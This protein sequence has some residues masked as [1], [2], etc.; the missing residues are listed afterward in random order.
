MATFATLLDEYAVPQWREHYLDYE[1][2]KE[3]LGQIYE[4]A[5]HRPPS[6]IDFEDDV[7]DDDGAVGDTD[8]PYVDDLDDDDFDEEEEL[9]E[10]TPESTSAEAETDEPVDRRE[11][12]RRRRKQRREEQ[13]R[14]AKRREKRRSQR[15]NMAAKL[16][17]DRAARMGPAHTAFFAAVDEEIERL[18][19]FVGAAEAFF[20]RR[21]ARLVERVAEVHQSLQPEQLGEMDASERERLRCDMQ[22]LQY[23][24]LVTGRGLQGLEDYSLI[25]LRGFEKALQQYERLSGAAAG[26][27]SGDGVRGVLAAI[28]K[29]PFYAAC[30]FERACSQLETLFYKHATLMKRV[31]KGTHKVPQTTQLRTARERLMTPR[32]A[33]E[34]PELAEFVCVFGGA[35]A[36]RMESDAIDAINHMVSPSVNAP[37]SL[38]DAKKSQEFWRQCRRLDAASLVTLAGVS[39]RVRGRHHSRSRSTSPSSPKELSDTLSTSGSGSESKRKKSRLSPLLLA[40]AA[41]VQPSKQDDLANGRIRGATEDGLDDVDDEEES[42]PL[43]AF[44]GGMGARLHDAALEEGPQARARKREERRRHKEEH[45]NLQQHLQQ[46]QRDVIQQQEQYEKM[47]KAKQKAKRRLPFPLVLLGVLMSLIA[48]ALAYYSNRHR[49]Q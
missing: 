12:R 6:A 44:G 4:S 32:E 9:E 49:F 41:V 2:L 39:R 22:A 24:M 10:P 26:C 35:E 25:N 47:L 20:R 5:H 21:V 18:N 15:L 16:T 29:E 28:E 34:R 19:R 3:R 30:P 13:Q 40:A 48:I 11:E 17:R 27:D 43:I 38:R 45:M 1:A 37:V 36:E 46:R 14:R 23:D 33:L 42:V 7:D 8:D 31:R